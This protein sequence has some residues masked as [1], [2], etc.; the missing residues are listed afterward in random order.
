MVSDKIQAN[1]QASMAGGHI[2]VMLEEAIDLL[3]VRPNRL[4]IDATA[5]AGGHLKRICQKAGSGKDVIAM[6]QD[7]LALRKLQGN[8][9]LLA[10]EIKFLH[11]NF[12]DL[13]I[14]LSD[15]NI[16][17]VDGGII[18]DL[19]VS[20]NQLDDSQR[21]FSFQREGPLDMRMNINNSVTAADL[22]ND[23]SETELANIIY[24][25]GEERH[26]RAIARAIMRNR[27]FTNTSQLAT[28]IESV[29]RQRYK[30]KL[31]PATRTFQALRIAVNNELENLEI[32]LEQAVSL[33]APGARLVVITFHSLEDR[34]V[35]RFF[36]HMASPCICPP[37][38]PICT[39]NKKAELLIITPKP[40]IA[41]EQEILANIR[42]RSAKL[43]AAEKLS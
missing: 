14:V 20:S 17:T 35:K 1:E 16:S 7:S 39:C 22:V 10:D 37:R 36:T 41:D 2:P 12:A 4:Y 28:I 5:G 43:R 25:Y 32:F 13:K 23:L 31:H 18:A 3:N 26:S 15:L 40:L 9:G 21:G 11:A 42:S 34:I 30:Y 8:S 33:L 27:P 19:G 6:D 38:H 24:K 29:S